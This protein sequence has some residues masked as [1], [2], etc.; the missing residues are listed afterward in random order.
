MHTPVC[1]SCHQYFFF[2]YT[3]VL[4]AHPEVNVSMA[5]CHRIVVIVDGITICFKKQAILQYSAGTN[6]IT[7]QWTHKKSA[8][9]LAPKF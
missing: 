9:R 5:I 3:Y 6:V 4:A 2:T 8:K 7:A 1:N